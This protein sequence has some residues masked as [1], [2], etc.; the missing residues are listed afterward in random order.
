[1]HVALAQVVGFIVVVC[2]VLRH[3]VSL[4]SPYCPGTHSVDQAVLELTEICLCLCVPN[5]GIGLCHCHP[6]GLGQVLVFS[7]FVFMSHLLSN[8]FCF[9]FFL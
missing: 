2:L 8:L 3:R 1:M 6:S 9:V 5:A 7:L 4:C